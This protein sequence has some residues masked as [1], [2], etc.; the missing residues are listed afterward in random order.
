MIGR[1]RHLWRNRLSRKVSA[2]YRVGRRARWAVPRRHRL[3]GWTGLTKSTRSKLLINGHEVFQGMLDLRQ[4]RFHQLCTIK[5]PHVVRRTQ[6][7]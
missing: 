4:H 2:R 1:W 5:V 6:L 3:L 7:G